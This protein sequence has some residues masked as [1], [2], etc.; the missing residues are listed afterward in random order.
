LEAIAR[1]IAGMEER[2]V[3]G[4]KVI[5]DRPNPWQHGD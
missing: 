1:K 2:E 5:E 3:A 4:V